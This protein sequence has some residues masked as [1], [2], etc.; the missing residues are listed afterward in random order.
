MSARHFTV[1]RPELTHVVDKEDSR[2][3]KEEVDNTDDT[4]SQETDGSSRQ[5]NLCED[6]RSVVDDGVDT[7][8]AVS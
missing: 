3:G 2:E 8:R 1:R 4:S 7:V 6:G 5:T